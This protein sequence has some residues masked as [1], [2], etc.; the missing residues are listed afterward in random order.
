MSFYFLDYIGYAKALCEA[1]NAQVDISCAR[2][3]N[4]LNLYCAL[5]NNLTYAEIAPSVS[6][7]ESC[8]RMHESFVFNGVLVNSHHVLLDAFFL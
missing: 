6:S 7:F 8:V 1:K 4:Y 2:G 5:C 3:Q